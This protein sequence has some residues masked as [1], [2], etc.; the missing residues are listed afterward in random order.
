MTESKMGKE[1]LPA[2]EYP[3]VE[4]FQQELLILGGV[5]V[6]Y[7][8]IGVKGPSGGSYGSLYKAW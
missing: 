7:N 4:Y 1:T 3:L 8:G 6:F 5:G 2:T